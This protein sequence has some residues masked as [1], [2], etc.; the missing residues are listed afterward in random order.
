MAKVSGGQKLEAALAKIAAG[1]NE[2]GTLRV[3][4]LENATYPDGTPV[5]MVGAIHE[6]GAPAAGIPPRSYFR[7]MIRAKSG[8]WPNA[9]AA[10]LKATKY[11]TKQTLGRVGM[12]IKGQLQDAI[13]TVVGPPLKPATIARKGHATLLIDTAHMLNSVDFEV[14]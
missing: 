8:D 9:I 13:R 10:N 14:K 7:P 4:F 5:A 3:G 1:L 12:G 2:G 6:Y 11:D